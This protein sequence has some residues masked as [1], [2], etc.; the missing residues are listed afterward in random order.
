MRILVAILF[1]SILAQAEG[2][3]PNIPGPTLI[4]PLK[5]DGAS[6][7]N[8]WIFPSP[9]REQFFIE[10]AALLSSLDGLVPEDVLLK[11]K[12]QISDKNVISQAKLDSLGILSKFDEKMLELN[13]T[14]NPELR[15]RAMVEVVT[16]PIPKFKNVITPSFF[17]GYLNFRGNQSIV[18]P[19]QEAQKSRQPFLGNVDLVNN[20]GGV[21]FETGADY[22]ER[23]QK[24]WR[25]N[26]SRIEFDD[27]KRMVR[28]TIGDLQLPFSGYQSSL[29]MGGVSVVR[30]FAIQPYATTRPLNA[31]EL[32]IKRPSNVEVYVNGQYSGRLF[33]QPG[34]VD[35]RSFPLASGLNNVEFRITDDMGQMESI[36]VPMLYDPQLLQE[37]LHQYAYSSGAP[38]TNTLVDRKYDSH[39]ITNTFFH[40]VG[41]NSNFT[42]GANLQFNEG[43]RLGGV[44][45][46]LMLKWGLIQNDLAASWVK[47]DKA[48]WASRFRFRTLEY[49]RG[50]LQLTRWSFESEFKDIHF[51]GLSSFVPVNPYSWSLDS[52]VTRSLPWQLNVGAGYKYQFSRTLDPD[53]KSIRADLTKNWSAS[54]RTSVNYSFTRDNLR[55][56]RVYAVLSWTE[57]SGRYYGNLSYDYPERT[58]RIDLTRNPVA[59]YDDVRISAGVQDSKIARSADLQTEYVGSRANLRLD[60]QTYDPKDTSGYN[61]ST[62]VF[63]SALVWTDSA[64]SISRP[65]GDSFMILPVRKHLRDY[66]I[67]INNNG[68]YADAET[69]AL[70]PMV[71]PSMVS[72]SYVPVVIDASALPMGYSVGRDFWAVKPTYKSG[73]TLLIGADA[74]LTVLGALLDTKGNPLSLM[75]GEIVDNDGKIVSGGF[76]TNRNGQFLVE[77]MKT[78]NYWLRFYDGDWKPVKLSVT[79]DYGMV[80]LE[81]IKVKRATE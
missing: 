4:A 10:G 12:A 35:L 16:S 40:R 70:G 31:T 11:V 56:H 28:Y 53:R 71:L 46:T 80:K 59:S 32:Y 43:Q 34:P 52:Y 21:V 25:R 29:P 36:Q 76:F 18:Y 26:D 19:H 22:T 30:Q 23:N 75:G 57:V 51:S 6:L 62:A 8:V 20:I 81:P 61:K 60:H 74:S 58:K 45:Q 72:Y 67:K 48:G 39:D 1:F 5:L 50:K 54:W 42:V 9:K 68:D 27:E 17:S 44:E 66:K 3:R 73:S 77:G 64:I 7:Q 47:G 38:Y 69:G 41:L 63:S 79:G 24:P 33:L 55:E 37:G 2:V 65:V 13:L 15:K 78:G 14:I 49:Y